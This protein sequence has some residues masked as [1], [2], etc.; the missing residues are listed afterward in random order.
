MT[1]PRRL[2]LAVLLCCA[3]TTGL[4]ACTPI[5]EDPTLAM[6]SDEVG[7]VRD[8]EDADDTE[9]AAEDWYPDT[10]EYWA[11]PEAGADLDLASPAASPAGV[12][13]T[14]VSPTA[15]ETGAGR[16]VVQ[17]L[18]VRDG[19]LS[20]RPVSP[21]CPADAEPA[22]LALAAHATATLV[23]LP[24]DEPAKEV[25]LPVLLDH[26]D[27]CLSGGEPEPPYACYGDTYD[28]VV[29]ARGRIT[30]IRELRASS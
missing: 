22:D 26:L 15:C 12:S 9:D 29:D 25:Q 18:D 21:G 16:R 4:A 5:D 10:E 13:P 6:S 3:V 20:V 7:D 17:V 2:L 30:R 11:A 19:R 28:L 27:T 23:D 8:A 24:H 14:A 1:A